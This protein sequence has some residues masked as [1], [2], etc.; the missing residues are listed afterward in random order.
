MLLQHDEKFNG[1]T[2]KHRPLSS[3]KRLWKQFSF[4]VWSHREENTGTLEKRRRKNT[5]TN[6]QKRGCQPQ[7]RCSSLLVTVW[8]N[9][10]P[11]CGAV[12]GLVSLVPVPLD[13]TIGHEDTPAHASAFCA[14]CS[15][16]S[17]QAQCQWCEMKRSAVSLLV[18]IWNPSG[19]RL[20]VFSASSPHRRQANWTNWNEGCSHSFVARVSA[21]KRAECGW[22]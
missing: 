5:K 13:F 3:L 6:K 2:D 16:A 8:N 17:T 11:G 7:C 20:A 14:C 15:L 1:H 21:L 19:Q 9:F 22:W 4:D 18:S 10:L 12:D